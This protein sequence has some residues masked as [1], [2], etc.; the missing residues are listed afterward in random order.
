MA[1]V[2]PRWLKPAVLALALVPLAVGI[3]GVISDLFF[4]SRYFG[5]NPI[6]EAEHYLGR[7]TL[8]M[9]MV[10]LAITPA[11]RI[12]GWNWLS[13][14]RRM[15]GVTAFFYALTHLLVYF[16]LDIELSWSEMLED[17][18]K[19][20]YVTIGMLAFLLLVPLAITSTAGMVKRLGGKR[21]AKLHKL[22]YV[23][24]ILGTIH[25]AMA[26]KKDITD[27]LIFGAG[28]ALLLCWRLWDWHS[29]RNAV[30]PPTADRRTATSP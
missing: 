28:F 25:F 26:Q 6:K 15:L 16:V 20:W 29:R 11:R 5:S 17:V 19:R 9:L 22:I 8:G 24:V 4:G 13:R 21:W 18:A 3:T 14:Y 2:A 23:V 10:T 12:L 1:W 7:W 30:R 27:P